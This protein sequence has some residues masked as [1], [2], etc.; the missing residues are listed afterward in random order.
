MAFE[1]KPFTF[2]EEHLYSELPLEEGSM[3][4]GTVG[5]VSAELIWYDFHH[6]W[7]PEDK[8]LENPAFRRELKLLL[9]ALRRGIFESE[10]A[11]SDFAPKVRPVQILGEYD[12][13]FKVQSE[14]Y[15][16]YICCRPKT[17]G[18]DITIRVYD[19]SFLLP[20]LAGKHKMPD[21]CFSVLPDSGTL[22]ILQQE[23]PYIQSF[24]SK[25]SVTVRQ[26]VANDLNEAMGVTKAQAAAMLMGALHGFNQPCAWPWQYDQNGEPRNYDRPGHKEKEAR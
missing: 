21:H 19:N 25:D 17:R 3:G 18:H 5:H 13:R 7:C 8:D 23:R 2:E 9:G 1:R 14:G 26:Q 6:M 12:I 24:E 15:S 11:L 10:P 20:E 22:V 16:Y 4:F